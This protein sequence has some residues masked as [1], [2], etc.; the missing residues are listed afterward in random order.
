MSDFTELRLQLAAVRDQLRQAK[1][2]LTLTQ[3]EA[4]QRAIDRVAGSYGKNEA[5]RARFLMLELARDLDYR[6]ALTAM[7][8]AEAEVDRLEALLEAAKDA[9]RVDEWAIRARLADAL[10]TAQVPSDRA[11]L[12]GD[13]AFDDTADRL[14]DLRHLPF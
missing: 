3:A 9:R 14:L 5:E 8:C 11:D 2:I 13:G 6:G 7:R 10:L 1:D 4:E 12:S